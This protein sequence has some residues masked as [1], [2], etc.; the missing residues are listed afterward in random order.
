MFDLLIGALFLFGTP[1]LL[2]FGWDWLAHKVTGKT[3]QQRAYDK[4]VERRKEQMLFGY[5][6][7]RIN[8]DAAKKFREEL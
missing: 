5:V 1:V 6:D 3:T 4:Q 2:W 7:G 8:E